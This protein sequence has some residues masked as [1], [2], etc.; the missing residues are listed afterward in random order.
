[1]NSK[2]CSYNEIW[3]RFGKTKRH[4]YYLCFQL[5]WQVSLNCL[6]NKKPYRRQYCPEKENPNNDIDNHSYQHIL[7]CL[8][9]VPW[10]EYDQKHDDIDKRYRHKDPK[11][12]PC[13]HTQ[14]LIIEHTHILSF[15]KH[16]KWYIYCIDTQGKISFIIFA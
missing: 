8:V 5:L 12:K 14:F 15:C 16:K 1:M 10:K 7:K 13:S 4:N 11:D 2:W 6:P 9:G 3:N